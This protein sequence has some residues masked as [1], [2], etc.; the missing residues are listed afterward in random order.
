MAQADVASRGAAAAA[1]DQSDAED[2]ARLGYR[3]EL[4]RD[5][6][7]LS[8]FAAGFS[9]VSIL[10]T[11]FQLFVIGYTFGG[12]RFFWTWPVVF[13]GQLAVALNLAEVG[14]NYPVAGSVYQWGRRVWSGYPGWLAGWLKL[15]GDVVSV[16]A[17]A[18]ALQAILPGLWGGF[19]LLGGD[20]SLTSRDGAANAVLLGAG[21]VV[22]TTAINMAGVKV[23]ACVNDLGVLAEL[24][25]V[26]LLIGAL[27]LHAVRGPEVVLAPVYGPPSSLGTGVAGLL[28]AALMPA[29]VLYG[30]DS[31]G[32]LAEETRSPRRIIPRAILKAI[33]VSG[34]GGALL[35]VAALM[36]APSLTDG[37]L[38][39]EGLA[40][41]VVSALGPTLGKVFLADVALAVCVCTL[42]IQTGASRLA[43]SMAR[44]G[45]LP[46][47]AALSRVSPRTRTPVGPAIAVGALACGMLL[48]NYGEAQL[49]V[50]ITESAVLLVNLSY[51]LVTSGMLVRRL[52]GWPGHAS[53]RGE[54]FS[55]GRAGLA[56]NAAAVLWGIALIANIAWPRH[57]GGSAWMQYFPVLSVIGT[58]AL[59]L[60]LH[61]ATQ[62][63]RGEQEGDEVPAQGASSASITL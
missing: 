14:S 22:L 12:T 21:L 43:F 10:T 48:V 25:G 55:L 45:A 57:D 26:V 39:S 4:K 36:A 53:A 24:G 13:L 50:L 30:F 38:S 3:Q 58:V 11:V 49:F 18:I 23:M 15:V 27:L 16:A 54:V 5:L 6:G 41:V 51:L 56:L 33:V 61:A 29:Y 63:P 62:R 2:L 37:R 60:A 19:Q 28:A 42:A 34:V 31:A 52:R 35:I 17:A 32:S 59:G 46:G 9:Y 20:P 8:A 1:A 47:A 40:Y 44:D 7:S